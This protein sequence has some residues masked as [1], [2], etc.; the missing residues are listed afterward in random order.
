TDVFLLE[1]FL[2]FLGRLFRG[3]AARL[4]HVESDEPQDNSSGDLER[5]KRNAEEPEDERSDGGENGEND[6]A[7]YGGDQSHVTPAGRVGI[8]REDEESRNGS[9]GVYEHEHGCER[10]QGGL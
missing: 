3:R 2:G 7:G 1:T 5:W 8:G 6:E 4:Q 10:D 9:D